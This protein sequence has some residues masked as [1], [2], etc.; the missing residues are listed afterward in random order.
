MAAPL[1]NP[2]FA[3]DPEEM[4][5]RLGQASDPPLQL[6][7]GEEVYRATQPKP[8]GGL[9]SGLNFAEL[10]GGNGVRKLIADQPAAKP[11]AAPASGFPLRGAQDGPDLPPVGAANF[12]TPPKPQMSQ[13]PQGGP[14]A[15]GSMLDA[16]A[17]FLRQSSGSGSPQASPF[18]PTPPGQFSPMA[19]PQMPGFSPVAMPEKT[20]F[21]PVRVDGAIPTGMFNPAGDSP[22]DRSMIA[23]SAEEELRLRQDAKYNQVLDMIRPGGIGMR[24]LQPWELQAMASLGGRQANDLTQGRQIASQES[25][26]ADD[27]V[28]KALMGNQQSQTQRDIASMESQSRAGVANLDAQTRLGVAGIEAGGR[29]NPESMKQQAIM[30]MAAAAIA[31][32]ADHETVAAHIASLKNALSTHGAIRGSTPGVT[33]TTGQTPTQVDVNDDEVIASRFLN[34]VGGIIGQ[35][36]IG[37][38]FKYKEGLGVGDA[39]KVLDFLASQRAGGK[40][41]PGTEAAFWR[42]AQRLPNFN[43]FRDD[44]VRSGAG[45]NYQIQPPMD[46]RT[47]KVADLRGDGA[48]QSPYVVSD[49]SGELYRYRVD[50]DYNV[51]RHFL[52]NLTNE[53]P[54]S[55]IVLPN[56]A[57]VVGINNSLMSPG[58]LS[59]KQSPETLKGRKAELDAMI[60]RLYPAAKK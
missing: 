55:Q 14:G 8:S 41:S 10:M 20:P 19:A 50:P 33:S 24:G 27:R 16:G 53:L 44:L 40:M 25:V 23:Y 34:Q 12:G 2:G 52:G 21:S 36:K 22:W 45:A 9:L 29:N 47:G 58:W 6:L 30:Q 59:G 1:F 28:L 56:G 4:I 54:Y 43:Q 39:A 13:A 35:G 60:R 3:F 38:E 11:D 7:N 42:Q 46:P 31:G 48:T 18:Q 5:R 17:D 37:P 51:G 49:D 57:G 32:G 26:A 15:F